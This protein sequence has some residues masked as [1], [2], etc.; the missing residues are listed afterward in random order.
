MSSIKTVYLTEVTKITKKSQFPKKKDFFSIFA[1]M[2]GIRLTLSL[3]AMLAA[4]SLF[5]QGNLPVELHNPVI[6]GFNPEPSCVAVGEDY[7][8]VTSSFDFFPGL[9]IYYSRDLQHWDQIG[10]V[11]ERAAQLPLAE[12]DAAQGIFS[13][14][15]RCNNGTFYIIA[16]N[17]GNGGNF[18][19]TAKDPAESWSDPIWLEQKGKN[20]S[21]YFEEGKCYMSYIHDS[22]V[23]LCE[24]NPRN[25]STLKQGKAIWN[26]T[27]RNSPESP[28]LYKHADWYYLLIS[29]GGDCLTVARSRNIYGPYESSHS[30]PIFTHSSIEGQNSTI[31]GTGH[32]D[33]FQ[34]A[35]GSWW[36]V[37]QAHRC[38]ESGFHH[39]GRETFLAPVSWAG[40]WPVIN[41]GQVISET[42]SAPLPAEAD[43]DM[44]GIWEY[45]FSTIGPEW[46]Y[47]QQPIA[48]NYTRSD[49]KLVLNGTGGGF[50]I[51]SIR[52]TAL[53]RRQQSPTCVF[54]TK[55][56]IT[57]KTGIAGIGIYQTSQGYIE[58]LVRKNGKKA[59]AVVRVRTRSI[60][61]EEAVIELKKP[62]ANLLVRAYENHYEFVVNGAD[63]CCVDTALI[64]SEVAG[65]YAGVSIGP[66]CISGTAEFDGFI[67]E[68]N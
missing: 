32:G 13:P 52:P 3:A 35:D 46:L 20:P 66:Y 14:T 16:T 24:I 51:G 8:L 21:L 53:L 56:R 55:V 33:L 37:M 31:Q 12:P 58:F 50:E 15:I 39:L 28:R 49:G 64:S 5:A 60:L 59:E 42:M 63:L 65:G 7:Y 19:V 4:V 23:F 26:G 40:G 17:E 1:T 47:I 10:N 11:L 67:Y 29:E 54:S 6:S 44:Y 62:M 36:I 43:D 22:A 34:A 38:F 30:N 25:G 2:R 9:P 41:D 61:H 18:L 48:K 68:E 57:Q 45:D 27:G